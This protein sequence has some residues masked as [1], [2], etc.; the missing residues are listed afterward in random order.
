MSV[1]W[2]RIYFFFWVGR[3]VSVFLQQNSF[4][5]LLQQNR[6]L[7]VFST[8]WETRFLIGSLGPAMTF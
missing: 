7:L 6:A 5:G 8:V 4:L 2:L 1:N 3:S